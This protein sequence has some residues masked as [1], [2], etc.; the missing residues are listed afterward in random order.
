MMITP[1][2]ILLILILS[3]LL[4]IASV[5]SATNPA[6]T[7]YLYNTTVSGVTPA[8]QILQSTNSNTTGWQPTRTITTTPLYWYSDTQTCT[9]TAGNWQFVLWTA[10]PAGASLVQ[11]EI[12]ATNADGSRAT[13]IGGQAIDVNTTGGGNHP[14]T[15]TYNGIADVSL[16]NQRLMV[17]IYKISGQDVMMA[18][19]TND[20]PSR[21]LSPGTSSGP[22]PTPTATPTI[23][24][25]TT[26][27]P[28]PDPNFWDRTNI[29]SANN[30]M[31]YKFLNRTYGKY[32]DTQIYWSFNGQTHSLA[33]QNYIDMPANSSG[34]VYFYVGSANSPYNDFI[35]HTIS[36]TV[37][38][39]N[40]TRVDAWGLPIALLLHC[41]DGYEVQLGDDQWCFQTDRDTV[42]NTFRS[43]VPPEFQHLAT[44]QYPYKIVSPG[45]GQFQAGGTYATYYDNYINQVWS[46]QNL[47]ITKP[48]T[49]E[50]FRCAGSMAS[51]P[52]IAAALNRHTA[53]LAQS[54]WAIN[55]NFYQSAPAN[56]YA[57]FW[58]SH[59]INGLAYGFPYDDVGGYAAYASHGN[60]QYLL[61]AIGF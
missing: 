30:V 20:F 19:N 6:T 12:Y 53:M 31:I 2:R 1:K 37:W 7:W 51:Q 59:G 8:G 45:A 54:Q 13:S 49:Q 50:V 24:P 29:P 35:E 57:Q 10:S 55:S 33:E 18:Y 32:S 40:T 27:S 34:R 5:Y 16:T 28:T 22:T 36:T 25:T 58:H 39:G 11:V 44:I 60:P 56:Y 52:D 41:A 26:P 9:Y 38:N 47:T 3:V 43:S 15:F 21:L 42:F 61:I 46:A 4:I 14:S 48:S 17:K 23:G